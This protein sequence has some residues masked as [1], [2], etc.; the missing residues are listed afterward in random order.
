MDG[1]YSEDQKRAEMLQSAGVAEPSDKNNDAA[2]ICQDGEILFIQEYNR[3]NMA[4]ATMVAGNARENTPASFINLAG[5]VRGL[6]ACRV[7][8]CASVSAV[9]DLV[10]S[11]EVYLLYQQR[12]HR[13]SS[14]G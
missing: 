6:V 11:A 4:V 10:V 3:E 1:L 7:C 14:V 12:G 5:L 13:P 8:G 2:L 9:A